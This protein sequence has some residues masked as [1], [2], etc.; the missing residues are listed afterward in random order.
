MRQAGLSGLP[1]AVQFQEPDVKGFFD[2]RKK[3]F[4]RMPDI[5]ASI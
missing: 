1:H 4:F 5:H 2:L 3:N